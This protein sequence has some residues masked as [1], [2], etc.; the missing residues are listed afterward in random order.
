M[1]YTVIFTPEATQTVTT[2]A[3]N[4]SITQISINLSTNIVSLSLVEVDDSGQPTGV[5][6]TDTMD[7]DT[8]KGLTIDQFVPAYATQT[9]NQTKDLSNS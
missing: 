9:G 1:H 3:K 7:W 8:C 5:P 4:I 2:P 6:Y